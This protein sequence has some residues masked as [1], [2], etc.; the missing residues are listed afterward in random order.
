[1]V[2]GGVGL[3]LPGMTW[4]YTSPVLPGALMAVLT[5]LVVYVLYLATLYAREKKRDKKDN[6]RH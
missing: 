2:P 6:A 3:G 4:A 1:M 5:G